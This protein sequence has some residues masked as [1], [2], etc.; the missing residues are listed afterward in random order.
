MTEEFK[1]GDP[2]K[3]GNLV[4]KFLVPPFSVLDQ[5]QAYWKEGLKKWGDFSEEEYSAPTG[6]VLAI[7]GVTLLALVAGVAAFAIIRKRQGKPIMP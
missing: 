3:K 2:K 6:K 1:M 7:G 5:K 4:K